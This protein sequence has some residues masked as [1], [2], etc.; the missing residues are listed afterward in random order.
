VNLAYSQGDRSASIRIP[1]TSTNPKAKRLEFRC[2]DASSNPYMGF[3]AMLCAGIDGINSK[4]D[5]GEPL[6]VDI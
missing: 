5:P 4:I 6:D 2:P 3:A 1:I